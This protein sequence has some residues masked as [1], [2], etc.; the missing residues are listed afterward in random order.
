MSRPAGI[1]AAALQP[2]KVLVVQTAMVWETFHSWTAT[3]KASDERTPCG[4][5]TPAIPL[6]IR[7]ASRSVLQNSF[8][9]CRMPA[10]RGFEIL[11]GLHRFR[12]T[13]GF[14]Q[15]T[16]EFPVLQRPARFGQQLQMYIR[17]GRWR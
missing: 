15:R 17:A 16:F 1:T 8:R 3:R 5:S 7:R 2:A 6:L 14:R 12:R 10:E 4:K 11:N 13:A 9:R